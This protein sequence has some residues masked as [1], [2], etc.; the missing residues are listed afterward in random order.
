MAESTIRGRSTFIM[1]QPRTASASAI[2]STRVAT[3][4]YRNAQSTSPTAMGRLVFA[5]QLDDDSSDAMDTSDDEVDFWGGESPRERMLHERLRTTSS[6]EDSSESDDEM[7]DEVVEGVEDDEEDEDDM[8]I[9]G[10]R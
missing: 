2:T 8:E 7:M 3:R 1:S 9:F 6:I 4:S 5:T 10:H